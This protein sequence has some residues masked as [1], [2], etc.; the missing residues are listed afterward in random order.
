[1]ANARDFERIARALAGTTS[2]P[3]FDR[4]AC[5]V[6]RTYATLSADRLSANLKLPFGEQQLKCLTAPDAFRP[7]AGAWG[8]QGWTTVT[9][10]ALST[11]ELASALDSAWR[12]AQP[13]KRMRKR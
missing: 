1:M 6:A 8:E 11:E 12:L 4:V 2:A 7:V 3:H 10:A 13:M 9:F 5:K